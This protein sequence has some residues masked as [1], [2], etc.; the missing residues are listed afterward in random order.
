MNETRSF[1]LK[2][3]HFDIIVAN[4]PNVFEDASVDSLIFIGSKERIQSPTSI[5][6]LNE[7]QFLEKHTIDQDKFSKNENYVFTV[8]ANEAVSGILERMRKSSSPLRDFFETT[9]G[10]NPYD[11]Y[12]GQSKEIITAKAYHA[13][14]KKD[15]TFIPEIRGKHIDRY[16]LQWDGKHYISY[17]PW[18]AAPRDPKFFKNERILFRQV[19]G[20]RLICTVIDDEIIIDQSIFIALP[21][22]DSIIASKYVLSLLTSKL[23][24]LYFKFSSNEFDELF[25]KIKLGEFN[26]LPIK[27][28]A[29]DEQLPFIAKADIMLSKNKELQEI[30]QQFLKLLYANKGLLEGNKG[31]Q[32]LVKREEPLAENKQSFTIPRK[33]QDW[34]ALSFKNFLKELTKQKIKLSLAEQTEWMTY[35]EEQKVKANAIKHVIDTTDKE[36]DQMVY[37][38]YGLTEEEIKIV[39][40]N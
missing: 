12:R 3:I 33:L 6:F 16:L 14:F 7:K 20:E 22:E 25:P 34:P 32:P 36:I 29:K 17:G 27:V 23:G 35:F 5:Q 24:S 40:G 38:L 30:K 28:I 15:E 10:V 11:S 18:L 2:N 21:K 19:L 26:E 1:L 8:E 4:L 9:R 31:L 13:D 39:E 37:E